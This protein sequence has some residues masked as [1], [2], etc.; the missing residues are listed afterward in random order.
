M[1]RNELTDVRRQSGNL[2]LL[3]SFELRSKVQRFFFGVEDDAGSELLLIALWQY[4]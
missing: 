4:A 1:R 3:I 2:F